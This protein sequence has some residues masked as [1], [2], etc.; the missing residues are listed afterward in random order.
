MPPDELADEID[1]LEAR[2]ASDPRTHTFARL[3]DLYRKAGELQRALEVVE[4]GL[5][6]HP[7]YLNARIVHAR[8]LRE[9]GRPGDAIAAF[10][11]VL[12]IDSENLVAKA[13]LNEL[14]EGQAGG[15]PVE[16]ETPET[17]PR[18]AASGWLARLEADWQDGRGEETAESS[19]PERPPSDLA[20]VPV[21]DAKAAP[22]SGVARVAPPEAAPVAPPDA[23]APPGPATEPA[24][25]D[26]SG[27][28]EPGASL[29]PSWTGESGPKDS[30]TDREAA[31][32]GEARLEGFEA[33]GAAEPAE[34]LRR[35]S[36]APVA[37]SAREEER[38]ADEAFGERAGEAHD[39]AAGPPPAREADEPEVAAGPEPEAARL[40]P[41]PS[42]PH[43]RT[44]IRRETGDLET[45]TLA[46]LYARQGL[47]DE[48]IGILERLLAR[49]PYNARLAASLEEA[50]LEARGKGRAGASS[51]QRECDEPGGG[52]AS[53]RDEPRPDRRRGDGRL[54][55]PGAGV[56]P[57]AGAPVPVRDPNAAGAESIRA[58]LGRLL[59]GRFEPPGGANTREDEFD[60]DAW[61]EANRV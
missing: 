57:T 25:A 5:R 31:P 6:H 14:R 43:P 18:P 4:S 48:A 13:A 35:E 37:G 15:E 42:P 2:S 40:Q 7:H 60:L 39:L 17:P 51:G 52:A 34:E 47:Y 10:E 26:R 41:D 58:F 29:D 19:A 21:A 36:E 33:P 59:E 46:E 38:P 16:S 50:R 45:A 23:I 49:D 61:L 9:L 8:L 20:T 28:A 56:D 53:G 32:V 11:R 1:R 12:R 54:E 44:A 55:R 27:S 24:V 30:G 3:A 22:E